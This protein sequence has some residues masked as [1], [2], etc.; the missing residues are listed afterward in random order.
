MDF[1][2]DSPVRSVRNIVVNGAKKVEAVHGAGVKDT[3]D[4]CVSTMAPI[5]LVRASRGFST[6]F[7][8]TLSAIAYRP[9]TKI[10]L[11]MSNRF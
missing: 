9:A 1:N 11:Q 7:V 10:G 8:N 5:Q 3:A 4:F 6:G 2:Y